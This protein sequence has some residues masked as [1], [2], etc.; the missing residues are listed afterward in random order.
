MKEKGIP[1]KA[2][3]VRAI[4]EGR[5]TQTRR[6]MKPQ[7]TDRGDGNINWKGQLAS[8]NYIATHLDCPYPIGTKLYVKETF[9]PWSDEFTKKMVRSKDAA[10]Y[11]ADYR[12]GTTS[13]E[14]GGCEHW[15]PSR[16]MPKWAARI[17]LEVTNVRVE[18]VQDISEADAKAE[19]VIIKPSAGIASNVCGGNPGPAQFEYYALWESING[20]GS[21]D[22][23]PWVWAYTFKRISPRPQ[24]VSTNKTHRDRHPGKTK[25]TR[26]PASCEARKAGENLWA[27]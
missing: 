19:G 16:F 15:K 20:K 3:M 24:V 14:F 23:N 7:P 4:L 22:S 8:C 26:P 12:N 9:S 18:R 6:V 10:V 2:E 21:W 25:Q 13:L 1:F 27:T 17:W 5:K 11:R